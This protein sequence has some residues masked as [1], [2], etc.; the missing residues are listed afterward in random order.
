MM[1]VKAKPNSCIIVLLALLWLTVASSA[2]SP[3]ALHRPARALIS[4]LVPSQEYEI[5]AKYADGATVLAKSAL[6]HAP[7]YGFLLHA[8]TEL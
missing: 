2:A 3:S 4:I 6:R 7:G 8:L 5:V 1:N